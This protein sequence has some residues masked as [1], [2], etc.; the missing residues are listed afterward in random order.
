M[1]TLPNTVCTRLVGVGAFLSVLCGLRRIPAKWRYLV[2]PSRRVTRTVGL[3]MQNGICP[4]YQ[5]H[6]VRL[7]TIKLRGNVSFIN[8]VPISWDMLRGIVSTPLNT[9]VCVSCG[10]VESYIADRRE[11]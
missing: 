6:D 3:P 11:E 2:P 7:Q 4:K 8:A 5:S 1:S 10:Y 9:Y